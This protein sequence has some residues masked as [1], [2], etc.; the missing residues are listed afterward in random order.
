[1][2]G[3]YCVLLMFAEEVRKIL[4]AFSNSFSHYKAT[5]NENKKTDGEM[6]LFA[7]IISSYDKGIL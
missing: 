2:S 5:E 4:T 6:F 3:N 1:M 7:Y